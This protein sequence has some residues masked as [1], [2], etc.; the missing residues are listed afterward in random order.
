MMQQ[1]IGAPL[2][3][4]DNYHYNDCDAGNYSCAAATA[5]HAGGAMEGG[6][7][8]VIRELGTAQADGLI[9]RAQIQEQVERIM[10]VRIEM[11]TLDVLSSDR[12][13]YNKLT[14]EKDVLSEAHRSLNLEAARE[15]I[16]LL[17]NEENSV[18]PLQPQQLKRLLVVG[19]AA[20][21]SSIPLGPYADGPAS[22]ATFLEEH[23]TTIL[24]GLASEAAHDGS[25]QVDFEPGCASTLCDDQSGFAKA[26]SHASMASAVIVVLNLV[27]SRRIEHTHTNKSGR[28]RKYRWHQS[29]ARLPPLRFLAAG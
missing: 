6:G 12:L 23:V 26:V 5:I 9:S 14:I 22:N 16:I 2:P 28:A 19:F 7:Q 18:L 25:W 24:Q 17:K 11:G 29:S 20:N 21:S 3:P 4:A 13:A 8:I 27:R 10:R 1:R 15:G